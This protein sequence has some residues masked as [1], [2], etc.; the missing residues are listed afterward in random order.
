MKSFRLMA[1]A[2]AAVCL[3]SI[4]ALAADVAGTWKWSVPGRDGQPREFTLKL[5]LKDGQLTGSL[6]GFRGETPIS[7]A[8]FK[9]GQVAFSVVR[10]Y[11]GNK[12]ETKYQGQLDGDTIKG[13]AE[14]PGRDGQVTKR[15]W[16]ATRAP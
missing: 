5:E 13:S 4:L 16:T 6:T 9:D 11:N 15:D 8:S 1:A 3:T 12:V 14:G 2:F 10:E 7:D